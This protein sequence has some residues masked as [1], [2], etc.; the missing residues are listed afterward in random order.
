[1]LGVLFFR[2][3]ISKEH[4]EIQLSVATGVIIITIN[5]S[6]IALYCRYAGM[7]YISDKHYQGVKHVGYV[8]AYWSMAFVL[9]YAT[10]PIDSLNPGIKAGS[11]GN[12]TDP[13]NTTP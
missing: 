12:S 4:F 9:K 13:D 7:P 3:Y 2:S 8:V 11:G 6:M 5:I 1:M 10:I